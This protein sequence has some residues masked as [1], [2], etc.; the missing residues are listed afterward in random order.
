MH[1]STG[2]TLRKMGNFKPLKEKAYL[3]I[4]EKVPV[5][6]KSGS[7]KVLGSDLTQTAGGLIWTMLEGYLIK[8]TVFGTFTL[9]KRLFLWSEYRDSNPR[10][11]GPEPSAIPN[12]AIPR[13]RKYYID[14]FV[15]CQVYGSKMLHM[16]H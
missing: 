8:I 16:H 6:V 5:W 1:F 12:F 13:L 10:P 2:K 14:Y 9:Q 3:G 15:V 4:Q 11:L 7:N